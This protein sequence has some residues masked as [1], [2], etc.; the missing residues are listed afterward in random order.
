[1]EVRIVGVVGAGTM[2]SGIAQVC[3]QF[4]YTVYIHDSSPSAVTSGLKRAR[5]NLER[6]VE[7][8][9]LTAEGVGAVLERIH[10]A[11]ALAD[12][13]TADLVVEAAYEDL[14]IKK[15]LFAALEET[16]S[17]SAILATNTSILSPTAIGAA[18]KTPRRTIGLHFFNPAPAMRLVEVTPGL[19]TAPET[20]A[21]VVEF[22]RALGK[23]PVVA[24]ESPGGIVSRILI[25]MRNEAVNML[26]EGVASKED[27]D[28]AMKLGAGFPMGPFEL[29]DLIGVDIHVLNS[30][31]LVRE[32][33]DAKYRPH[34]LL[35]NMYRAGRLGRK[36]GRG[37]YDY[38]KK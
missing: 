9:R 7:K 22:C 27:I 34:P 19:Q 23:T 25:A 33:G 12:L 32:L 31:S 1:L 8:G 18:V 6:Q 16:C 11:T 14:D 24:R 3:A 21:T 5:H 36:T 20:I 15:Q 10:E 37:F 28:T 13:A 29:I 35:R 30:D 2:G 17:A 26:A 4:G 38:A